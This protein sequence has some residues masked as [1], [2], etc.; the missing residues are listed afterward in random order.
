MDEG[1]QKIQTYKISHEYAMY[2]IGDII[3]HT[4]KVMLKILQARLKQY[5]NHQHP[6]IQADFWKRQRKKVKLPT[7]A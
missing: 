2:I 5:V 3:S 4:S 7:S 6:D 1:D